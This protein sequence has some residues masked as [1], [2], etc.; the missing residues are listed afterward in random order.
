[1]EEK[2][3]PY[4]RR[5]TGVPGGSWWITT[6]SSSI[7]STERRGNFSLKGS[8]RRGAHPGISRLTRPHSLHIMVENATAGSSRCQG[9]A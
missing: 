8:G 3:I 5:D 4:T 7:C 9:F 1:M 2:G 6:G